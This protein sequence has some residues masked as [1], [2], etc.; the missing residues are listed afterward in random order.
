MGDAFLQVE[1]AR[2]HYGGVCALDGVDFSM[3]LGRVQC[4]A[5]GNGSGKSTLIKIIAGVEQP[6]AGTTLRV[7]GR[8]RR[9][10]TASASVREGIEVIYQDLSLFPNLA[11]GENIALGG[12][13]REGR[14]W[15]SGRQARSVAVEALG[16]IGVE[17]D[18]SARVGELSV[19]E[20]QLVA[21][22][23]ALTAQPRFLIMDEPTTALTRREI[24][25]LFGVVRGLVGQGIGVL[26]VSHKLDEV[27]EIASRVTVLRDGRK[28]GDYAA[29]DLDAERLER[30][31]AGEMLERWERHGNG[32][33]GPTVLKVRGLSR[34]GQ[35]EGI[36]LEVRQGEVVGLTGLLGAGRTELAMS[37]FGLN[38]PDSGEVR[39][40]GDRVRIGSV[41]EAME[42]GIGYV[43]ED[44][45]V[46]GLILDHAIGWNLTLPRLRKW[47]GRN[48]WLCGRREQE[49][50][51]AE[52]RAFGIR[53]G[54]QGLAARTLSGGNQQRLVL[55]K[56]LAT[57]PRL[58]LL[59][60]PTVG[61]DVGAKRD[62]HRM[63]RVHAAGGMGILLITDELSEVLAV[64][65]R[66]YVMKEGRMAG[67]YVSATTSLGTV[68]ALLEES[69]E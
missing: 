55:G 57:K 48:G 54:G 37:L 22:A 49:S 47:V 63:I 4:L 6:D 56:W 15:M 38:P 65:D 3:Y 11:V 61:V 13:V 17:M 35:F 28:V 40:A 25:A 2:K 14:I 42:L 24:D 53:T 52:L 1:G 33:G 9:H 43:P 27:L 66:F 12:W 20:Q 45:A 31:I 32:Q 69:V 5:G 39:I 44:R 16:R 29:G 64:T 67:E 34:R 7:E 8:V 10:W 51:E 26:F 58:L 50:V 41:R 60:S 68:R 62:L 36:D 18:V 23:R 46:Q 21:V 30:L 59:D 19:A